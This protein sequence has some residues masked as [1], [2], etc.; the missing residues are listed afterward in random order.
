MALFVITVIKG[1][2]RC[3]ISKLNSSFITL[4]K[5]TDVYLSATKQIRRDKMAKLRRFLVTM[6]CYSMDDRWMIGAWNVYG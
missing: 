1:S 3:S 2:V 4:S 6:T 5:D